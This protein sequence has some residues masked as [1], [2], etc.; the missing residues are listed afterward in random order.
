MNVSGAGDL[1]EMFSHSHLCFT[2]NSLKRRKFSLSASSPG[3]NTFL[4]SV[5]RGE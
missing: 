5:V 2:E 4:I 3:K 1:V